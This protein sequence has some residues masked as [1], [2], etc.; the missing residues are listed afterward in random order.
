MPTMDNTT[1]EKDNK[2]VEIGKPE[3]ILLPDTL[4]SLFNTNTM[5]IMVV[6]GVSLILITLMIVF[7]YKLI[8]KRYLKRRILACHNEDSIPE[9][10]H[11]EDILNIAV[12]SEVEGHESFRQS[13]ID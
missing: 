11:Y 9:P 8:R 10:V 5:S 13:D 1:V 4:G 12:L 7:A 6:S 2:T 3:K